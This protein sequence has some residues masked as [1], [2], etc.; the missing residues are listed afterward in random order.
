MT[1]DATSFR[2]ACDSL[3]TAGIVLRRGYPGRP[4]PAYTARVELARS[5]CHHLWDLGDPL[6]VGALSPGEARTLADFAG[7]RVATATSLILAT[8]HERADALC[9]ALAAGE[10]WRPPPPGTGVTALKRLYFPD[11]HQQIELY[12][13]EVLFFFHTTTMPKRCLVRTF[14]RAVAHAPRHKGD[15]DQNAVAHIMDTAFSPELNDAIF[16]IA[17]SL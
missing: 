11:Y 5:R 16:A 14:A 8:E 12:W 9:A 2:V 7:V 10:A 3:S 13:S 15:Y 1:L 4:S 17:E 6:V